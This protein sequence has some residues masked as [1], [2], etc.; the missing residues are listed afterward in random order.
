MRG[1]VA[2]TRQRRLEAC[3]ERLCSQGCDAVRTH[4]RALRAGARHPDYA[5]LDRAERRL[6]LQALESVMRVYDRR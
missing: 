3:V 1:R 2:M 4:I 6:L 5:G